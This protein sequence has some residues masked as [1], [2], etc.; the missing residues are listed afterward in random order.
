MKKMICIALCICILSVATY[1]NASEEYRCYHIDVAVDFDMVL[2]ECQRLFAEKTGMR[3]EQ[4]QQLEYTWSGS[5]RDLVLTPVPG[6]GINPQ[7]AMWEITIET[8]DE[9]GYCHYLLY[10]CDMNKQPL[11]TGPYDY[12]YHEYLPKSNDFFKAWEDAYDSQFAG[13]DE[14]AR[15]LEEEKGPYFLWSYK[16][17]AAF[18]DQWKMEP[19]IRDFY[20]TGI[21]NDYECC[22]EP[23]EN[24][25]PYDVVI[26]MAKEAVV[27]TFQVS[28][29]LLAAFYEDVRFCC[30]KNYPEEPH[31]VIRYWAYVDC[32]GV[33]FWEPFFLISITREG[34][35]RTCTIE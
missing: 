17:K 16:D 28:D 3:L 1:A 27:D 4:V 22:F 13:T 25:V 31:W 2:R 35:L 8:F 24:D 10:N 19:F 33:Q 14:A 29:D 6:H 34:T 9:A 32:G 26:Q 30:L 11:S 21:I 15:A 18:F 20:T 12:I 5:P 23:E 7:N